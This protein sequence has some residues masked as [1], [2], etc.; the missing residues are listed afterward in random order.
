MSVQDA[1][2]V[3]RKM[4]SL[5]RKPAPST[6]AS[7]QSTPR[8][9]CFNDPFWKGHAPNALDGD[10]PPA[11]QRP[12]AEPR[13]LKRVRRST[14]PVASLEVRGGNDREDRTPRLAAWDPE[15]VRPREGDEEPV[16]SAQRGGADSDRRWSD[17]NS[18]LSALRA[19]P[20]G[21][22]FLD[23]RGRVVRTNPAAIELLKLPE[24]EVLG[25][26][27]RDLLGNQRIEVHDDGYWSV[28]TTADNPL[29]SR[30][31]DLRRIGREGQD[32]FWTILDTTEQRRLEAL[33]NAVN[34]VEQTGYVFAGIRHE[35]GNPVHSVKMALSVLKKHGETFPQ[36]KRSEFYAKMLDE[37]ERIE[38]L[39]GALRNYNA[40][41]SQALEAF[42]LNE[43]ISTFLRVADIGVSEGVDVV[44]T[45]MAES[46]WVHGDPRGLYQVLLNLVKNA[47]DAVERESAAKIT[48]S[49]GRRGQM[50]VVSVSDNGT[51]M[52]AKHLESI[53]RP[54][55]T[56]KTH[57]TGLG[58]CVSQRI[59]TGMNGVLEF[60]STVGEG[61]TAHVLL[62]VDSPT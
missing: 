52:S 14:E 30:I 35:L 6:D 45:P 55:S 4:L 32:T 29:V 9:L 28:T 24:D 31:I 58:L 61:T 43:H 27:L 13:L 3:T 41:E 42:E 18:V 40:H 26:T 56:T 21:L 54:F 46:L 1:P 8:I 59:L 12:S 49:V 37:I 57:G 10:T 34:L 33:A 7:F 51:G 20:Q 39:L 47:S 19:S 2:P 60:E 17:L 15:P 44:W 50:A 5:Y 48:L 36:E 38:F 22:L 11:L 23:L 25:K 62:L 16:V 53:G